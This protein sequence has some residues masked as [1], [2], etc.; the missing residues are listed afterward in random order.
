MASSHSH[1]WTIS[2][3]KQWQPLLL[4]LF[5]TCPE[6]LEVVCV[7]ELSVWTFGLC[8]FEFRNSEER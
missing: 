8:P 5:A 3:G 4:T 2:E 6:L 1:F 7:A